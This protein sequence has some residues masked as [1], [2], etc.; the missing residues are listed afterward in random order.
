MDQQIFEQSL[1]FQEE[2]HPSDTNGFS[3]NTEI[4]RRV[5]YPENYGI[6]QT[7]Q[8]GYQSY[9]PQDYINQAQTQ[10]NT[11]EITSNYTQNW[12][13]NWTMN[14]QLHDDDNQ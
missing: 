11:E 1:P 8:T 13:F 3:C 4:D 6:R 2:Q 7:D 14:M 12:K 9:N 10:A 5:V